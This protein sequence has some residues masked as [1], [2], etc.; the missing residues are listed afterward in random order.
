MPMTSSDNPMEQV[1]N[2]LRNEIETRPPTLGLVGVSGVGKSSTANALFRTD[3]PTSSTVACT[4]EFRD[5]PLSV[6]F[7]DRKNR[8]DTASLV[9]IDAPGLGEDVAKDP[10]YLR[11][12]HDNLG[13]CDVILWV[14]SARNRAVALDQR[15]LRELH[16]FHDRMVLGINQIDLVD[17]MDWVRKHNIPSAEQERNIERIESDRLARMSTVTSS[18][19]PVVSYSARYGYQ[20]QELFTTIL[21]ACPKDRRWIFSGLQNFSYRDFIPSL[22]EKSGGEQPGN[23]HGI[24]R[25]IFR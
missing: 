9:V 3:L 24:F 16:M 4:K 20:L 12:Y 22:N 6:E 21:K 5:V 10:E 18:E 25:S 13:G 8:L 15:Y 19:L 11:M 7:H 23:R 2:A 1:A 14:M 17:P